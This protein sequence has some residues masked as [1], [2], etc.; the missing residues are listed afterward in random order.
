MKKYDRAFEAAATKLSHAASLTVVDLNAGLLPDEPAFTAALI[1]RFKD[2]VS[3][4][5]AGISWTAKILS[6]HGPNTEE[7]KFGADL[8]GVLRINF[9]EY[10][11][12][13]GFLAQAK[14]QRA[15]KKLSRQEWNRM[16]NQCLDMLR[17][18]PESFVFVY[19]EDGVHMV[20]AIAVVACQQSHDLHDLHPIT[21][22][23]FYAEH[24]RCFI[25][26]RRIDAPTAGVLDGLSYARA[27]EI[28]AESKGGSSA[29]DVHQ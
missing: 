9:P 18:T 15:G 22:G 4:S 6:S 25:G 1:T 21:T 20:P 24:F 12:A 17:R 19:S 29:R 23:R 5:F 10:Q 3:G 26:D 28:I 7:G 2:A 27:I 8:L 13:K 11:V 16:R 14:K